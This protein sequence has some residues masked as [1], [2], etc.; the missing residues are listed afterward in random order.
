VTAR[1]EKLLA[2]GGI[3]LVIA[4]VFGPLLL[5]PGAS[6][7]YDVYRAF[8]PWSYFF[9]RSIQAGEYPEWNPLTLGGAPF[10][11]NPQTWALYPPNIVRALLHVHPTPMGTLAG[12]ALLALLHVCVL[13]FGTYRLARAHELT[14]A[15]AAVAMLG[16]SLNALVV[17]RVAELHFIFTLAWLPFLLLHARAFVR[18]ET[19]RQR[20]HEATWL[21]CYAALAVLGGFPQLYPYLAAGVLAYVLVERLSDARLHEAMSAQPLAGRTRRL[22][23]LLQQDL[24]YAVPAASLLVALAACLLLPAQE[25]ASLSGRITGAQSAADGH[26]PAQWTLGYAWRALAMYSG[27]QYEPE[28]LRGAGIGVLALAGAGVVGGVSRRSASWLVALYVFIDLLI[29]APMPIASAIALVSPFQMVSATRAADVGLVF[30]ALVAGAGLDALRSEITW[31][32]VLAAV[33]ALG[34]G[35]AALFTLHYQLDRG[36]GWLV[37]NSA[38]LVMP[39]ALLVAAAGTALVARSANLSARAL[40]LLLVALVGGELLAWNGP[41]ARQLIVHR[42]F[43]REWLSTTDVTGKNPFWPDNRREADDR[44]NFG[45]FTLRGQI[46]G[47]DPLHLDGVRRFLASKSRG[48]RYERTVR[49]EETVAR[50]ARAHLFMKRAFWLVPA[51][52]VGAQPPRKTLYPPTEVAFVSKQPKRVPA[53][54]RVD[55]IGR[56]VSPDA[57][58]TMLELPKLRRL[59]AS[60][61]KQRARATTRWVSLPPQHAVLEVVLRASGRVAVA[62][63]IERPATDPTVPRE[64]LALELEAMSSEVS[65]QRLE[66]PLPDLTELRAVL[67]LSWDGAQQSPELISIAVLSDPR[68]E[69]AKIQVVGR[70]ADE[71]RLRVNELPAPR[72]LA[73]SD[74]EYPGWRAEVD[75]KPERIVRTADVFKGIELRD[76]SHEV[77]F[78]FYSSRLHLGL[79]L[80]ALA[81][82]LSVVV[83]WWT[84]PR[85]KSD[86]AT[87]A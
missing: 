26:L 3:A 58:R 11:A 36:R 69:N 34:V 38:M 74:A 50:S 32:R 48:R 23:T 12:L 78:Y 27:A 65:E 54:Q 7:K 76:G 63:R 71:V 66:I 83:L 31:R 62:P 14:P 21:A 75:G 57:T 87:P 51:V 42:D 84:R 10:A 40:P 86:A 73:F 22:W 47:Y 61:G 72:F 17:R 44:P 37:P 79:W 28:T 18:A 24:V 35:G 19:P 68:D 33:A 46:N 81:L 59:P 8:G 5:E 15:A 85:Y 45:M 52:V 49:V 29:G 9:D 30:M 82:V 1:F 2:A 53:R 67:E 77:R 6:G 64:V 39:A 70:T 13:G 80:S 55:V 41:Y 43:N 56:G 4:V 16:A 60:A 25:F 20:L